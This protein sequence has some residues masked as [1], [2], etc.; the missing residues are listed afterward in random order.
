MQKH[1][2]MRITCSGGC[3]IPQPFLLTCP[4]K[5]GNRGKPEWVHFNRDPPWLAELL[6]SLCLSAPVDEVPS[7]LPAATAAGLSPELAQGQGAAGFPERLPHLW[8]GFQRGL[9]HLGEAA[10][11][12]AASSDG[13]F[14][15]GCLIWGKQLPE[16]LPHL[17]G[18]FKEAASSVRGASRGAASSDGAPMGAGSGAGASTALGD[19]PWS[20]GNCCWDASPQSFRGSSQI[21]IFIKQEIVSVFS[22]DN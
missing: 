3:L 15:R 13:G 20:P 17:M 11:R 8:G 7:R 1:P 5:L 10:S 4:Q 6:P 21:W 12:E 22:I 18:A 2:F 9:P 14:Q 16:R 19:Y